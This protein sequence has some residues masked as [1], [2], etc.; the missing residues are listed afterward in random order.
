[1][2][3][4]PGL[5]DHPDFADHEHVSFFSDPKSGLRAIVAVHST[6]PMGVAGGGCRMVP[7]AS[8]AEALTDVLRL[9]KAMSYKLALAGLPSG[10]AKSVVIAD[11]RKDKS[12]ALLKALGRSVDRLGGK[13]IIAEDVGTTPA[14]MEIIATQTQFVVGRKADTTPST[15]YGVFVGLKQG[16]ERKLERELKGLHV[17]IQGVGGVGRHLAKHLADAGATLTVT[18]VDEEAVKKMVDAHGAKAVAPDAIYDV[19]ADVFAPCALGAIIN[20]ATIERL[21]VKMIAGGANNQLERPE[22]GKRLDERGILFLPDYVLN[23]GGVLGAAQEGLQLGGEEGDI[24]EAKAF[25]SCD[26]IAKVL[27]D[28]FKRSQSEGLLPFEAADA[29]AE[30]AV[31]EMRKLRG[32]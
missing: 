29:L 25:E 3:T 28:V 8:S 22:H 15:G 20:D 2:D 23:M 12:E 18:D 4:V 9:S 7:Y 10:G 13:Y 32:D 5:F 26:R 1:M 30:D 11:P 21:K 27:D 16:V 6:A 31:E 14:D 24:D 19:E 17:A